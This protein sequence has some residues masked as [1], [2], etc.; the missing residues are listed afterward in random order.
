VTGESSAA[1][2]LEV[3]SVR[4]LVFVDPAAAELGPAGLVAEQLRAGGRV[5]LLNAGIDALECLDWAGVLAAMLPPVAGDNPLVRAESISAVGCGLWDGLRLS[6]TDLIE[7]NGE[8]LA[9][10]CDRTV[11]AEF[12]VG[13]GRLV[14]LPGRW[15]GRQHLEDNAVAII[16]AST[17]VIGSAEEQAN[18]LRRSQPGV[19]SPAPTVD[20]VTAQGWD[21]SLLAEAGSDVNTAAFTRAAGHAGRLLPADVHD[22]LVDFADAGNDAGAL[23]LRGVP[24][25][26]LPPTPASPSSAGK[27]NKVSEFALLTVARR[28]GQPVGYAPEHGGDLIQNI[29]PVARD[30]ERQVS[31]SSKSPLAFHTEAAFHPHRPRYLLLLCLKGDAGAAT[32][33]CSVRTLVDAMSPRDRA[34]LATARFTTSA[35]ESYVGGPSSQRSFPRPILTGDLARPKLWLDADLM[36]GTDD[37]AQG[38]LDRISALASELATGVVLE[39]G[40]LLVVDNDV[41]V[42]GRSPFKPRFDGTDRWL[43]RTFVVADHTAADGERIGRIIGTRFLA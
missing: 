39:A 42:H 38:A 16:R 17:G 4:P 24:V 11:V 43:Q 28:L 34:V 1:F 15:T 41:A 14:V 30:A 37:E 20:S 6:L 23:L 2:L 12:T 25:G 18:L 8:P 10:A 33:L 7:L 27:L 31:T 13:S 21:V 22:A 32:T 3:T 29:S 26:E 35:D 36:R 19:R 5:V 40:D 9:Q